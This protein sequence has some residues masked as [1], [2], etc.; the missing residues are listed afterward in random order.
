M[1][2]PITKEHAPKI[3]RELYNTFQNYISTH[4]NNQLNSS[5]KM[6]MLAAQSI[7]SM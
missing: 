3:L 2:D 6:I 1:N 4:P 5:M 7:A